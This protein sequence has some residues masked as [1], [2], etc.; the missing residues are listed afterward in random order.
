MHG[1]VTPDTVTNQGDAPG[2]RPSLTGFTAGA[3]T[4]ALTGAQSPKRAPL[5]VAPFFPFWKN[6]HAPR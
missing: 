6:L 4:T 3:G 1:R 2:M 5:V